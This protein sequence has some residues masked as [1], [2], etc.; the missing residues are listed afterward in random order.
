[1]PPRRSASNIERNSYLYDAEE[2]LHFYQSYIL[3]SGD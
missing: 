2:D 3:T 1:M